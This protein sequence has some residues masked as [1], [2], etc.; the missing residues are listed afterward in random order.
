MENVVPARFSLRDFLHLLFKRKVQIL[1]CFFATTFVVTIATFLIQST[2]EAKAQILVKIGRQNLY[3]P[4][5][6]ANGHFINYSRDDQINSEIELLKSRSLAQKAINALGPE[7][8]LGAKSKVGKLFDTFS[9]I[10]TQFFS[11]EQTDTSLEDAVLKFEQSLSVIGVKKSEVIV[12]KFKHQDPD[13]A[14][15]IVNTLVDLYLDE[16]LLI[17]RN[18]QTHS[19]FEEQSQ[20]LKDKLTHAE[21]KLKSFKKDNNLTDLDEQQRLLLNHI[22]NLQSELNSTLS[23]QA[24]TENRIHQISR[25]LDKTAKTVPQWEEVDHSPIL[26]NDLKAKL[27]ELKLKEKEFSTKYTPQSRRLKNVK[28]EIAILQ[29][30]LAKMESK[31][32]GKSRVGP[33]ATSEKLQ[34]ELFRNQAESKALAAKKETQSS[35]LADYQ[36]K[37]DLLNQMAVK[38]NHLEQAVDLNR[39]NHRLYLAKI[40]ESRIS[41]AMD[42]KKISNVSLMEPALAPLKP[43]SPKKLFN[44]II[45]FF[46]GAFGG[47]GLAFLIEFFD[48]SL[49]NPEQAEIILKLPVLASVPD[50]KTQ[51]SGPHFQGNK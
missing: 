37:L 20:V 5:N 42:N 50:F 23:L 1:I 16:H 31:R 19:F 10:K 35:Q 43:E 48:D 15:L 24:E 49:E 18:P 46:M 29:N 13:T 26:I 38:L 41:D 33:N 39:Q 30:N 14:A 6:S 32:Y 47:L 4:P 28:E 3:L 7:I 9:K 21:E 40:E 27:V 51:I 2:Y 22:S 11:R 44:L 36:S 45:G 8:I 12:I 34:N 17:H 25:Q